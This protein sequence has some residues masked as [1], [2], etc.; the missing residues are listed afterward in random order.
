MKSVRDRP[1]FRAL[2]ML[3]AVRWEYT[4]DGDVD[5]DTEDTLHEYQGEATTDVSPYGDRSYMFE[6][7]GTYLCGPD[8]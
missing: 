8:S 6:G 1:R 4:S 3:G 2:E 5:Y 7:Y